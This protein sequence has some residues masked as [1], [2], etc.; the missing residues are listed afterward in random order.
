MKDGMPN[1]ARV[2]FDELLAE[3]KDK[4][5]VLR[6][7]LHVSEVVE[8][9]RDRSCHE[10]VWETCEPEVDAADSLARA[11]VLCHWARRHGRDCKQLVELARAVLEVLP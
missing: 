10:Y 8:A 9:L 5:Q 7:H 2:E 4:D 1:S 3:L 6:R 11:L